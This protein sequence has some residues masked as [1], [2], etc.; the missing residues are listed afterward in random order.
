MKGV[1]KTTDAWWPDTTPCTHPQPQHSYQRNPVQRAVR[2]VP[3]VVLPCYVHARDRATVRM[4]A[5]GYHLCK[6]LAVGVPG[7]WL[8]ATPLLL[9]HLRGQLRQRAVAQ[10]VHF[11]PALVAVFLVI[12]MVV[13][14][15]RH[16]DNV[17]ADHVLG[18]AARNEPH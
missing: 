7:E 2:N 6:R 12:E 10:H 18:R 5:L 14:V 11:V 1:T 15:A 9:A 3:G 16:V 17:D 13:D 8:P 4:R